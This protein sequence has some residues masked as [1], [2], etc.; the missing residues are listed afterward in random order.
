MKQMFITGEY[1]KTVQQVTK[2]CKLK[3]KCWKFKDEIN[4]TPEN[5]KEV[6]SEYE[7]VQMK[8]MELFRV[9]VELEQQKIDKKIID[10]EILDKKHK[11]SISVKEAE[12]KIYDANYYE[13][14]Q[15]QEAFQQEKIEK[16]RTF[17]FPRIQQ[18]VLTSSYSIIDE[19][20]FEAFNFGTIVEFIRHY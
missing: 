6:K 18:R 9:I 12:L 15:V 1:K 19:I 11:P 5:L 20:I 10:L 13:V 17:E 7:N 16:L 3:Q 8:Y 14:H 4:F 2:N